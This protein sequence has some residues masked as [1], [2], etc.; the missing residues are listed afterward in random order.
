MT[1]FEAATLGLFSCF[2]K[3]K[4]FSKKV[5][6]PKNGATWQ[7]LRS[8]RLIRAELDAKS[9]LTEEL[10]M[11]IVSMTVTEPGGRP[12]ADQ[13][14]RTSSSPQSDSILVKLKRENQELKAAYSKTMNENRVLQVRF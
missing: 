8:S 6:P 12:R 9:R 10:K 7:D 4:Q 13:L 5:A 14:L 3:L 11:L 2:V 1:L